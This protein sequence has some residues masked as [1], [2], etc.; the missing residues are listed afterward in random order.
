MATVRS[1]VRL[2]LFGPVR[3]PVD[4]HI[5]DAAAAQKGA[6][7]RLATVAF[8]YVRAVISLRPEK[9]SEMVCVV[10]GAVDAHALRICVNIVSDED[11]ADC[12]H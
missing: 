9:G 3:A 5:V 11:A 7:E 6:I 4:C 1:F 8:V 12:A 2:P 10:C